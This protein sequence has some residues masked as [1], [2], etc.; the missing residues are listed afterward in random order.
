[1]QVC[2]TSGDIPQEHCSLLVYFK[3][4][5]KHCVCCLCIFLS[6]VC[7]SAHAHEGQESGRGVFYHSPLSVLLQLCLT[8]EPDTH[9]FSD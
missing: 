1:M 9:A 6:A 5:K 3:K 4:K 7:T 2:R 8:S